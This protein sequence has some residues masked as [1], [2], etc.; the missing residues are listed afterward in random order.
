M[1]V[2]LALQGH[3]S[4]EKLAAAM[5]SRGLQVFSVPDIKGVLDAAVQAKLVLAVVDPRLLQAA[6]VDIREQLRKHAGY[7][8][9]IVA[10]TNRYEEEYAPIFQLHGA[11]ILEHPPEETADVAGWIHALAARLSTGGRD[12]GTGGHWHATGTDGAGTGVVLGANG[13]GPSVLVVEDEPTFR[14]FLCEAL[15]D[16]GYKVWASPSAE[17]ALAFFEKEKADLVIADI[18]MPG[19][20]GFELKQRMD[21]WAK[22]P[23]PF[24]MMTADSNAEN[25]ANAS[26]VGVVFI[27]GKPIRNLEAL[28]TIVAETLRK[29]GIS[30]PGG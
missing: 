29:A 12:A 21:Q 27:L 8:T 18:N 2:A 25:A 17:E 4:R 22:S 26:A 11:T 30:A 15:G 23:V 24:I 9:Q 1:N 19:M 13:P 28:Y 20:D 3:R 16:V 14:G 7:G 5:R 10:L 6:Q